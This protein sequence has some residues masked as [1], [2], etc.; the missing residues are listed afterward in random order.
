[1][2]NENAVYI[3]PKIPTLLS[4]DLSTSAT[5][6]AKFHLETGE[7]LSFGVIIPDFKNPTKKGV[8]T[9][10]YPTAQVLK[11]RRLSAQ[12]LELIDSDVEKIVIEEIN[13]GVQ[14]IGQKVL[15]GLHFILLEKFPPGALARV[16]YEDSDG[17]YGWRSANGLKLQL[18]DGDKLVNK[19]R[20]KANKK[21]A[22]GQKKF[23]IITQKT[24]ACRFVNKQFGLSLDN[25]LRETDGDI[26]D[27]IGLGYFA[28]KKVLYAIRTAS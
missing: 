28:W 22:K 15:D 16:F 17:R 18:S 26:A 13:R 23:S 12:I 10:A 1:M 14:R 27:A 8:P 6:W 21:L 3:K 7:L 25:D 19:E 20:K 2:T 5:G 9:Y 24:L 4:L 11:I